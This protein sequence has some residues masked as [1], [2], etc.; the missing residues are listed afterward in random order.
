[1]NSNFQNWPSNTQIGYQTFAGF[2]L[3]LS[4]Q[5]SKNSKL[6]F[7][8]TRNLIDNLI[9]K[10]I[11][12]PLKVFPHINLN[13]NFWEINK[14]LKLLKSNNQFLLDH[15]PNINLPKSLLLNHLIH[16]QLQSHSYQKIHSSHLT[17]LSLDHH[18]DIICSTGGNSLNQLFCSILHHDSS[19]ESSKFIA[20]SSPAWTFRTPI[21]QLINGPSLNSNGEAF[22]LA[23][24]H[25]STSLLSY[26]PPAFTINQLNHYNHHLKLI[27]KLNTFDTNRT[28]H[29][30]GCLG[31]TTNPFPH[32]II[33]NNHGQL[34]KTDGNHPSSMAKLI[35]QIKFKQLDQNTFA[36]C[37]VYPNNDHLV[38]GFRD[39]LCLIDHRSNNQFIKLY[40]VLDGRSITDIQRYINHSSPHLRMISTTSSI[41]FLDDRKPQIPILNIKHFRAQDLTLKMAFFPQTSTFLQSFDPQETSQESLNQAI[42]WSSSNDLANLYCFQSHLEMPPI[43]T[44]YPLALP[45]TTSSLA[46]SRTNLLPIFRKNHNQP[47]S[48]LDLIEMMQDGSLWH[49]QVDLTSP[50]NKASTTINSNKGQ[51]SCRYVWDAA[52]T[53]KQ[54]EINRSIDVGGVLQGVFK[55][56]VD[57]NAICQDFTKG[58]LSREIPTNFDELSVLPSSHFFNPLGF[59]TSA[60]SQ[61]SPARS[62]SHNS[63][64]IKPST[65]STP[66]QSCSNFESIIDIKP[67]M[68]SILPKSN[69]LEKKQVIDMEK[70]LSNYNTK[71][72]KK[73]DD[74]L[75]A[76]VRASYQ[77]RYPD[78]SSHIKS[79]VNVSNSLDAV[80][81]LMQDWEIGKPTCE[82]QWKDLFSEESTQLSEVE[83]DSTPCTPR[84]PSQSQK[85]PGSQST[86]HFTSTSKTAHTGLETPKANNRRF[87]TPNLFSSPPGVTS[88]SSSQQLS[89][90]NRP[91]ESQPEVEMSPDVFSCNRGAFSQ[92]LPGPH[93]DSRNDSEMRASKKKKRMGGF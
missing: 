57:F 92:V 2:R 27:Y 23:R 10:P 32:L 5:N 89:T 16:D 15:H 52:L 26:T 88:H 69:S 60:P 25:D 40:N 50:D 81:C 62:N 22:F 53:E 41:I 85:S 82:Y 17:G 36:K 74:L 47:S 11:L 4:N 9:L 67:V 93:G 87:T 51:Q 18:A 66:L 58:F 42:L 48:K 3:K 12:P 75:E 14:P 39:H 63:S 7:D 35:G 28:I 65:P 72:E 73:V 37:G 31:H 70:S 71:V 68:C 8:F 83:I 64:P 90:P 80:D 29:I 49:Q 34:W 13:S 21:Q 38:V 20:I 33:L 44:S 6:Q 1:M 59:I 54:S 56:N 76:A 77:T 84:H 91:F 46:N 24:T 79:D 86:I 19:S 43:I 61:S 45:L 55:N 78:L 30:D